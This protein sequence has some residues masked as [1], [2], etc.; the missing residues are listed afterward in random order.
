MLMHTRGILVM[1]PTSAMVLTGK[2]ALD[3][4]GGVS[5]EDNLGIGGYDRVMGPNGQAQYW[6]ADLE[7]A[8]RL[9]LRAL[10]PHLR[11]PGRAL[12]APQRDRR[13][14]RPRR[15]DARRTPRST[16]P[17]CTRRR[18]LLRRRNPERKKPFDM[19]SVMRAVAD[20]G[21]ASRWS[22]GPAGG[23]PRRRSSGTR[24]SAASRL[25]ARARVPDRCRAAVSS[26]RTDPPAWTSGRCSRSPRARSA[27]AVNAASGN[28]P[29]VVLANLSGF[30]GSPESMR[31]W[32]LE[33]GAEIGRAVTNFAGPI[34]FVSSPATT[35]V[36]S[37]CSPRAQRR[38]WR[39]PR[40]RAPSPRSSAARRPRRP[41]SPARSSD[42][43]RATRGASSCATRDGGGRAA[44]RPAD[45]PRPGGA[46]RP[47]RCVR[48]SCGE[49]ADEFDAIHT[50]ERALRVGSVDR[51]IPA[52]TL[53][54]YVVDALERGMAR[55]TARLTARHTVGPERTA[56]PG[57]HRPCSRRSTEP[58]SVTGA[59]SGASAAR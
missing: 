42:A 17:T 28:R 14:A 6:A 54:P 58:A 43:S 55:V 44:P 18:R 26:P 5:A 13:P 29:L 21:R 12:P 15:P 40:S 8:V 23:T 22:G 25:H 19:R 37:S 46:G 35:A 36:P 10:R 11:G 34:V 7:D 49:V 48:R 50:I 53:R 3:F 39:S 30:D 56:H 51:I 2:Q 31:N 24:T 16:A 47:R 59:G 52:A 41:S 32:Q 27:R 38:P 20:A 4:S 33:Y 57:V 45:A 1:L 9:L